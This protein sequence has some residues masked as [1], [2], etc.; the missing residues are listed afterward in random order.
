MHQFE[1][2]TAADF[3][4]YDPVRTHTQGGSKQVSNG[5]LAPAL[6]IAV[7]RFKLN[8]VLLLQLHFASVLNDD[9]AFTVGD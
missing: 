6:G 5:D 8:D 9:N 2:F 7:L 4:D 1:R 3:S